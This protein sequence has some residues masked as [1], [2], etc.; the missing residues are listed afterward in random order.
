M[1]FEA[2]SVE[3]TDRT[4]VA[5][6]VL[7]LSEAQSIP[8]AEAPEPLLVRLV[9]HSGNDRS[10]IVS[11]GSE[12]ARIEPGT[13]LRG[14][15]ITSLH[16]LVMARLAQQSLAAL[17]T[18]AH[19][20][21]IVARDRLVRQRMTTEQ[22][23][24][25]LA[26]LRTASQVSLDPWAARL[27]PDVSLVFDGVQTLRFATSG[28]AR[29]DSTSTCILVPK[30]Y[31]NM[32]MSWLPPEELNPDDLAY[33]FQAT[34][35]RFALAGS[36]GWL[37]RVVMK[38]EEDPLSAIVRILREGKVADQGLPPVQPIGQLL[39]L[40]MGRTETVMVGADWFQYRGKA[41]SLPKAYERIL[42]CAGGR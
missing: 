32:L 26:L 34:E 6:A 8:K 33:L 2:Q 21:E 11:I 16:E 18:G 40:V 13:Y 9:F 27:Y 25:S 39:F 19:E 20:V 35:L 17:F 12:T 36:D 14:P 5:N 3:I 23:T 30:S 28:Y 37:N 4:V 42:A 10:E 41:Y 38:N 24:Q 1:F 15:S 22:R 31:W 7:L 29:L